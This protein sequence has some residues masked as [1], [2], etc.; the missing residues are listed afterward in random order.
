MVHHLPALTD[1]GDVGREHKVQAD[2]HQIPSTPKELHYVCFWYILWFQWSTYWWRFIVIVVTGLTLHCL[3]WNLDT[4]LGSRAGVAHWRQLGNR[5]CHD[6][7]RHTGCSG[8]GGISPEPHSDILNTLNWDQLTSPQRVSLTKTP[9]GRCSRPL[10]DASSIGSQ[11]DASCTQHQ[12]GT[13]SVA[14]FVN[15]PLF[16]IIKVYIFESNQTPFTVNQLSSTP[17]C[18]PAISC[19]KVGLTIFFCLCKWNWIPQANSHDEM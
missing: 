7:S 3:Q 14:S 15:F 19:F 13:Y 2:S 16:W 12:P 4:R 9:G 1:L 10:A 11:G 8:A 17:V 18:C 6:C 5:S